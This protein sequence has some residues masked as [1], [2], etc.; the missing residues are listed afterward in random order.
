M[1]S[2][3]SLEQ[4]LLKFGHFGITI[5][6]SFVVLV[7][8]WWMISLKNR[9][10]FYYNFWP[11]EYEFSNF[12]IM[13]SR[14]I[15][16][17]TEI[18]GLFYLNEEWWLECQSCELHL[19]ALKYEMQDVWSNGHNILFMF[20]IWDPFY[21]RLL[22][23]SMFITSFKTGSAKCWVFGRVMIIRNSRC[24]WCCNLNDSWNILCGK[25]TVK[26]AFGKR[27]M[28]NSLCI[29][30]VDYLVEVPSHVD[31]LSS[32]S[33]KRGKFLWSSAVHVFKDSL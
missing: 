2:S 10:L 23:Y 13:W 6:G 17:Y 15:C 24:N 27:K 18:W 12:R 20:V 31:Q 21:G 33:I 7:W 25:R 9:N 32:I 8:K 29:N 28:V 14:R 4:K 11:E 19:D 22:F 16:A 1:Y 26:C 30:C 3:K 5:S